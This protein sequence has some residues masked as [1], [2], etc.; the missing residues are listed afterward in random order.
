MLGKRF[1]FSR[2]LRSLPFNE[3]HYKGA[4]Q[5]SKSEMKDAELCHPKTLAYVFLFITVIAVP[6]EPSTSRF[7]DN[8][9]T[10]LASLCAVI[11]G[12]P[13]K[14]EVSRKKVSAYG[15]L[16]FFLSQSCGFSSAPVWSRLASLSVKEQL[17]TNTLVGAGAAG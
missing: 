12:N 10:Q 7:R 15:F 13:Y 16:V 3:V 6:S 5:D 11:C 9:S 14:R 4:E 2:A 17:S 1:V 8:G